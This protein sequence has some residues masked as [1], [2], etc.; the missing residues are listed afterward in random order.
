MPEAQPI[1]HL[2]QAG[3]SVPF[4]IHTMEWIAR[5]R[6]QQ[7]STAHKHDYFVIV[8][9]IRGAGTHLVDLE[10]HNISDNTI[11][12]ISPGQIHLLQ[13]TPGTTGYVISF[14][15]EFLSLSDENYGLL[16]QGGLFQSYGGT[17]VM[18]VTPE[19]QEE[20]QTAVKMM[21]KEFSN[22][23]L[24][25]AEILRG[26]LKIFLIY[27]T[28][29]LAEE[30]REEQHSGNMGLMKRFNELLE[31]NFIH[32]KMVADYAAE[33]VVTPNYLNEVIKK[34]SGTPASEHIRQR[35]ILEAKRKAA[36]SHASMKEIAYSLGF[37]DGAHFSKYFKNATGMNFSDFKKSLQ[38]VT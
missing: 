36:F 25:R 32:K 11:Y 15:P 8:W 30:K 24:L 34:V 29:H 10:K 33:L 7:N 28:R 16:Y 20:L 26:Y 37:E 18:D 9:I 3:T 6:W 1:L 4:E 22:Y 35:V 5:N 14:T 23:F 21:E 17:S 31:K 13:A 19:M 12:C 38:Q 2:V 27:L